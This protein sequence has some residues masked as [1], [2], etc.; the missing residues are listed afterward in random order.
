MNSL[1]KDAAEKAVKESS[2]AKATDDKEK[3]E[4]PKPETEK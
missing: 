2:S 3:K 1:K 4:D